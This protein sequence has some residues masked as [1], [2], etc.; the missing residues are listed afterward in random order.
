MLKTLH[1]LFLSSSMNEGG[2]WTTWKGVAWVEWEDGHV[3]NAQSVGG[4]AD[5]QGDSRTPAQ[6]GVTFGLVRRQSGQQRRVSVGR[7]QGLTEGRSDRLTN[8]RRA[9]DRKDE[10]T[11]GQMDGCAEDG[12][13]N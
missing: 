5:G 1:V 7:A 2:V 13:T 8:S 9:D 12:R 11:V 6:T 3:G 10:R 4:R